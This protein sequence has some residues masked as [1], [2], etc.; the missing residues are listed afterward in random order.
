MIPPIQ[1]S[2]YNNIANARQLQPSQ[3]KAQQGVEVYDLSRPRKAQTAGVFD[4]W[5]NP[6]R[7]RAPGASNGRSLDILA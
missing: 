6:E 7:Y 3:R 2:S 5:I 4:L 1:H